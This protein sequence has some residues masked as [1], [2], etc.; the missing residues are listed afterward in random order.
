MKPSR[1]FFIACFAIPF[2]GLLQV[3]PPTLDEFWKQWHQR[4]LD[5]TTKEGLRFIRANAIQWKPSIITDMVRDAKVHAEE[6][7]GRTMTY[8]IAILNMPDRKGCKAVILKLENSTDEDTH[9]IASDFQ[10][11]IKDVEAGR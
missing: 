9:K 2:A 8:S 10:A 5:L 3:Q 11:D 7:E 1:L 4:N 6:S